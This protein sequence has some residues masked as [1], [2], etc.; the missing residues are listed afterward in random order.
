MDAFEPIRVEAAGLHETLVSNGADPLRPLELVLAAAAHLDVEIAWLEAGD[1]QLKGARALY[2]DQSGTVCCESVGD[3]SERA[4]LVA[5]ELGHHELHG[6]SA[7]CADSDI[8]PTRSIEAAPVGLERVEDYGARE[9]RELQANVFARELVLPRAMAQALHIEQSLTASAIAASTKLPIGLVRQQLFDALLLP[10][11][12]PN[13]EPSPPPPVRRPDPSQDRAAAHRGTPFQLQAGPGT[14]KT[15]TLVRR[16]ASLL[17]DGVDPAAILILTFS[18]RAAGELSERLTVAAPETASKLWIGTFHSFGLDLIRRH[19]D[20]LELSKNPTMFDRSDAIAVL[21]EIL[22]T[23]PLVHYRNLWDPAMV[24]RDIVAA[25]SRAKDEMVGPGGYRALATAM[26]DTAVGEVQR[27]AAEKCIEIAAIYDLYEEAKR[28][29]GGV[30]FGDLIMRPA[31]LLEKDEAIRVAVRLRHRHVLVDEYQDVNRASAHLLKMVAG[32]GERLWVV[33]DARQSIYR[34]RGASSTNMVRFGTDYPGAVVDRLDVNYRSTGPIV[35][36]VTAVAPHMRASAGMLPLA[37]KADRGSS[38]H[39]PEVRQFELPHDEAAGV[40]ASIREL[41]ADGVRLR[42]PT[43]TT[44]R[45]RTM[46]NPRG[47]RLPQGTSS[48]KARGC[49]RRPLECRAWSLRVRSERVSL[50]GA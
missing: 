30:D 12:V 22:P 15:R 18:N 33:G 7:S 20:R 44:E 16:V 5:H 43:R 40:A 14:G 25:I 6:G 11:S 35:Q 1:P 39:Q 8:D 9:K 29:H 48:P 17:G 26:R 31:R 2:D 50:S 21:E 13:D 23:L 49:S 3:E 41:E 27:V 36:T 42:L 38:P 19:Y 24:L 37:L 10:R 34:F 45:R 28:K 46:H 32:N 4:L 47:A